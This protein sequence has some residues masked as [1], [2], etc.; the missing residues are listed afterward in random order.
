MVIWLFMFWALPSSHLS[1]FS[2]VA[3]AFCSCT[4]SHFAHVLWVSV[5]FGRRSV[6]RKTH[7]CE[8]TMSCRLLQMQ[9]LLG[10]CL[11]KG[12]NPC[13]YCLWII[14]ISIFSTD[15]WNIPL[16]HSSSHYYSSWLSSMNPYSRSCIHSFHEHQRSC[17]GAW[18]HLRPGNASS[19]QPPPWIW[20]IVNGWVLLAGW[21]GLAVGVCLF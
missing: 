17:T 16:I 12:I 1:P 21:L 8:K 11:A 7:I 15:S 19:I 18:Y 5:L 2:S 20:V 14:T 6:I 9:S 10:I 4:S 13:G 3:G